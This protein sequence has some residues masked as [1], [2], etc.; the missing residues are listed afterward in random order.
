MRIAFMSAILCAAFSLP[1]LA[2]SGTAPAPA[3]NPDQVICIRKSAPTGTFLQPKPECHTRAEWK[4]NPNGFSAPATGNGD[5]KTYGSIEPR[6]NSN[7]T[8]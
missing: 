1:A 8:P 2:D 6:G 5:V 7:P 4:A 3:P